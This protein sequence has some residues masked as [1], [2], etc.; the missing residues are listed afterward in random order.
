MKIFK[1]KAISNDSALIITTI[2]ATQMIE[3]H[4]I[5]GK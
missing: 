4:K 5:R 1:I 3:T 2:V